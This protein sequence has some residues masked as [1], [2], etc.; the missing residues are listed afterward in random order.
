MFLIIYTHRRQSRQQNEPPKWDNLNHLCILILINPAADF[1]TIPHRRKTV[2]E[3]QK[4]VSSVMPITQSVFTVTVDPQDLSSQAVE[5]F[6]QK[7]H[8]SI[9]GTYSPNVPTRA[10][11]LR[12]KANARLCCSLSGIANCIILVQPLQ[13]STF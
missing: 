10:S 2:E 9:H 6:N 13:N 12:C 7:Q 11:C 8:H 5:V 4:T 3:L 1:T